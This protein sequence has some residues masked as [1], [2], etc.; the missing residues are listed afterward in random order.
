MSRINAPF[1]GW[2]FLFVSISLTLWHI[3]NHDPPDW[4]FAVSP[5]VDSSQ[6]SP[7]FEKVF[8]YVSPNGSA[9]SPA[10]RPAGEEF[11]LI[12][13][14]GTRESHSDVAI[15]ESAFRFRD[16]KW[17]AGTPKPLLT[18]EVLASVSSPRQVVLSLG[19]TIANMAAPDQLFATV[20][21]AGG[22]AASSIAAVNLKDGV[23]IFMRK[24]SLSPFLNRSHLVRS[25]TLQYRDSTTAIPA[26]FEMGNAFGELIRLNP[27]GRVIDKR[28]MSQGRFGIQPEIIVQNE[29]NALALLR[30]F[31]DATDR[32]IASHTQDG[33][34]SWSKA[35]LTD[36]PN[37]NSPVSAISL[38]TGEFLLVFNDSTTDTSIL[39][40]AISDDGGKSW[41][42]IYTLEYE[43]GAARYPMMRSLPSGEIILVYSYSSKRGIKAFAFNESWVLSQ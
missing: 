20:V 33:G 36:L 6:A 15:Y 10:I 11:S 17:I 18:K 42:R 22:W 5:P 31:D 16:G 34:R 3:A 25:P 4:R 8:D 12:W 35:E 14:D 41:K 43:E 27:E 30:N 2:L 28:R 7:H 32:L 37:P 29:N 13:F 21:S 9:H 39:K 1:G 24:L 40:L 38:S 19:N 23:P 26:Y